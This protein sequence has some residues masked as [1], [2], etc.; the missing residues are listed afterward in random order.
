M[1]IGRRR[2]N[3]LHALEE[4]GLLLEVLVDDYVGRDEATIIN[5][6]HSIAR[7]LSSPVEGTA[8]IDDGPV[9][10]IGEVVFIPAHTP[11]RVK[12]DS[13]SLKL[14][15]LEF[16]E[17]RFPI[18][19]YTLKSHAPPLANLV[20]VQ[21]ATIARLLLMLFMEAEAPRPAAN[22][23]LNGITNVI[24]AEL[25]RNLIEI[26]TTTIN[27]FSES[28]GL[29]LD[30][31][32]DYIASN[33]HR[34]ISVSDIAIIYGISERQIGRMFRDATGFTVRDYIEHV[35][36]SRAVHLLTNSRMSV[37][38]IAFRLGYASPASFSRAFRRASGKPPSDYLK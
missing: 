23:Y 4:E 16:A 38:Q 3:V 19:G 32:N 1:M 6:R 30:I 5:A 27:Y 14:V 22:I 34:H 12:G 2:R 8:W 26:N 7:R 10:N 31:A 37:K 35:K 24:V 20:N 29:D 18:I 28:D 25:V 15:R 11:I 21:N 9:T 13:G 33:I 36:I 17:E